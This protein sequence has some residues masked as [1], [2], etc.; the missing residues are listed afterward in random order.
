MSTKEIKRIVKERDI[1]YLLHFTRL[2]NL[3]GILEHGIY[4][5]SRLEELPHEVIIN[6]EGRW[7]YRPDSVSLSVCFPNYKMFY[8]YRN[9]TEDDWAVLIIHPNVLWE[10]NCAFCKHN[11]ADGRISCLPLESINDY[12]ALNELFDEIESH[13]SREEQKL[14]PCDP[15][16]PQAEVLAFDIII[17]EKV[18]GVVFRTKAAK[19]EYA[20]KYPDLKV[21]HHR[22]SKGMFASRTYVRE[23]V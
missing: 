5:H 20:E 23:Y 22:E 9:E 16:D 3:D 10:S 7:D 18:L 14:K 19:I 6:D 12:N 17:P 4:P 1:Q 21:W 11:A 15:T 8:K 2:R 13:R